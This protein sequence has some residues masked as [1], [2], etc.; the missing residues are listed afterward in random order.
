MLRNN[1]D[2]SVRKNDETP[3]RKDLSTNASILIGQIRNDPV[4][5]NKLRNMCKDLVTIRDT[6]SK[7]AS[8]DALHKLENVVKNYGNR[9]ESELANQKS[10]RFSRD[11]MTEGVQ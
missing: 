8:G 1:K 6:K 3:R 9:V 11:G 2:T 4:L 10:S 5:A 7:T